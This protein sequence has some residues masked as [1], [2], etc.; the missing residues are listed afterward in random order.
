MELYI[1]QLQTPE[2]QDSSPQFPSSQTICSTD[3]SN[4]PKLM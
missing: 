4:E 3:A 2:W 1:P